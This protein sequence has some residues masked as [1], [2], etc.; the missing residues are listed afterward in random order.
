LQSDV[1]II[2]IKKP[3]PPTPSPAERGSAGN[4][5]LEDES[6]VWFNL[7]GDESLFGLICLRLKA[8]SKLFYLR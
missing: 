1:F 4:N 8:L 7:L 3:H 5:S 6:L 2:I